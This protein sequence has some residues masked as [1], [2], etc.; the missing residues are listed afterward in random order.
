MHLGSSS[1]LNKKFMEKL[2]IFL[3]LLSTSLCCTWK[4]EWD[5]KPFS[6]NYSL[7]CFLHADW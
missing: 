5:K 3:H 6:R 1:L 2:L 7:L 4:I